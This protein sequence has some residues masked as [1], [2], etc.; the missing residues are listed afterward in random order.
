MKEISA[1]RQVNK[2]ENLKQLWKNA[3][4]KKEIEAEYEKKQK[5]IKTEKKENFRRYQ[6]EMRKIDVNKQEYQG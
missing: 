3:L 4:E 1:I 2:Q 6:D 5:E